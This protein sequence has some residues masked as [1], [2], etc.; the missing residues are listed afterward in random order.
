MTKVLIHTTLPKYAENVT[1]TPLL[2]NITGYT[3]PWHFGEDVLRKGKRRKMKQG[4][5]NLTEG[6]ITKAIAQFSIPILLTNLLQQLYN[7]IDSAVVGHFCGDAALAA[8]GSTGSLINLLIGFFLGLATGAGVLFAMYY[9]AGD[10]KG[11]KKLIDSSMLLAVIIGV[12]TTFVGVVFTRQLLG[13]MDMSEETIAP[14]EE[15]LRI[16]M[17]GT[18]ITLIYNVGAGLIRA[19]GDSIRPLIYLAIGGIGNL[20]MD[21][22]A[23]GVLNM[24]V[25]GAAWATVFAQ[26]ITA[27]L[28][29]IRLCRLNPEYAFKPLHIK[30]DRLTVWDV[31]RISV[32]CGLQSAMYNIS[33]LLVQIKINSFG[34][35]AMAGTTAYGKIDAFVYMPMAALSLAIS[36]FVGQNIGAGKYGR[37]KK[38]IWVTLFMSIGCSL[39]LIGIVAVFY[40]DLV[41]IFTTDPEAIQYGYSML[42]YLLPVIWFYSFVDILSGAIRG[43]GQAVSVTVICALMIC[44]FRIIWLEAL[45]P[46]FNDIRIVYL[47]YPISWILCG[48]TLIWF[49]YRHSTLHKAIVANAALEKGMS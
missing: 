19:E 3:M 38:A 22:L 27:I 14:A 15:Y 11:L 28:V 16:Y 12:F 17:G 1:K 41:L 21:L 4:N 26:T 34:T 45:L 25:A 20:V 7:S 10:Y 40:K 29:V 31:V 35:A 6:S 37:M 13:I 36:T 47:C 39:V 24:G 44:V 5:I 18:I 2:L 33:N 32:P 8:V 43:S 48:F 9:G 46:I 23:V 30:P 42:C 49:Y